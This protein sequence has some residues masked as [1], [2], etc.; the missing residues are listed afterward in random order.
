MEI[1]LLREIPWEACV[2]NLQ[3]IVKFLEKLQMFGEK[4]KLKKGGKTPSNFPLI[5]IFNLQ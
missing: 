5:F 1:F 3:I 4:G 2:C